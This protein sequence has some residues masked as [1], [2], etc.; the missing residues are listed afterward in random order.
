MKRL[1]ILLLIFTCF[2]SCKKVEKI[3]HINTNYSLTVVE[4][5]VKINAVSLKLDISGDDF[6]AVSVL[7]NEDSISL[8]SEIQN[9]KKGAALEQRGYEYSCQLSRKKINSKRV[10]YSFCIEKSD[11]SLHYTDIK[12]TPFG[13]FDFTFNNIDEDRILRS[14]YRDDWEKAKTCNCDIEANIYN[15]VGNSSDWEVVLDNR[16]Q[17]FALIAN[18]AG[19]S[20]FQ[21]KLPEGISSGKHELK[22][23]VQGVEVYYTTFFVPIGRWITATIHPER[24]LAPMYYFF[25]Q[26]TINI[27]AYHSVKGESMTTVMHGKWEPTANKW[28]VVEVVPDTLMNYVFEPQTLGWE[29]DGKVYFAPHEYYSDEKE[30]LYYQQ[31][32]RSLDPTTNKWEDH[33]VL[34]ALVKDTRRTLNTLSTEMHQNKLYLLQY[35]YDGEWSLAD[36]HIHTYDPRNGQYKKVMTLSLPVETEWAQL[37][38]NENDFYVVGFLKYENPLN[39]SDREIKIYKVSETVKSMQL[40]S[41]IKVSDEYRL[42]SSLQGEIYVLGK[43]N[44]PYSAITTAAFGHGFDVVTKQWEKLN[45]SYMN[46]FPNMLP[47]SGVLGN[48]NGKLYNLMGQYGGIFEWDVNYRR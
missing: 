40:L 36:Y 8:I 10:Y 14:A 18:G 26:N 38:R 47:T 31:Y 41:T 7:H 3:Q 22:I 33:L 48:L 4:R 13:S 15:Y 20:L 25:Y 11:G 6:S 34:R 29:I 44:N 17:N 37:V 39:S 46:Y 28:S 35:G 23:V 9:Q 32:I 27:V 1:H 30:K 45:P 24:G 2:F 43:L 12:S 42:A 16:T 19:N 21:L 5:E